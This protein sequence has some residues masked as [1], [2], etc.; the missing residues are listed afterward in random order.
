MAVQR[1]VGVAVIVLALLV[2]RSAVFDRARWRNPAMAPV[3]AV[4]GVALIVAALVIVG[5]SFLPHG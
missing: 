3:V 5:A 1:I 2:I 4:Q